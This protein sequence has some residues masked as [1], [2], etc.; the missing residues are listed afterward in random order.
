MAAFT[1]KANGNWSASGQ[2]TWTQVGVPGNGDTVTIN[3]NITVDVNTTIGS[4]PATGGTAAIACDLSTNNPVILTVG[5][6]NTLR[7]RG[8][9]QNNSGNAVHLSIVLNA[10]SSLLLDPPCQ[11]LITR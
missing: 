4:S 9:I 10:G 5:T 11:R 6:G 1:S 7:V 3:H 2:T 8:D